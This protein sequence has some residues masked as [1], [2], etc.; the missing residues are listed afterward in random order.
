ML[1]LDLLVPSRLGAS[2]VTK[3]GPEP[4][5]PAGPTSFGASPGQTSVSNRK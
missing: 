4:V 1:Y 3:T 5:K 2:S